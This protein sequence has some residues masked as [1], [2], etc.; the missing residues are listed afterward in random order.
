[1]ITEGLGWLEN[2]DGIPADEEIGYMNEESSTVNG[3]GKNMRGED[4]R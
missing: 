2:I 1:M 4:P 3:T